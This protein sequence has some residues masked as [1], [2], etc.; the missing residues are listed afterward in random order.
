[1]VYITKESAWAK[2]DTSYMKVKEEHLQLSNSKVKL[3]YKVMEVFQ[4]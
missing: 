4:N 2:P 3:H 1:M